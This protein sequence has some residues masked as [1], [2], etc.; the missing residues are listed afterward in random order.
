MDLGVLP[1]A[2]RGIDAR[3]LHLIKDGDGNLRTRSETVLVLFLGMDDDCRRLNTH[4]AQSR[5][6]KRLWYANPLAAFEKEG[7]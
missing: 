6:G 5:S 2:A 4:V 1:D 7:G 3:M